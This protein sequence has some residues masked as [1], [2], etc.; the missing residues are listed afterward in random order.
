MIQDPTRPERAPGEH[1]LTRSEE[2]Y[3]LVT[4]ATRDVIWDWDLRT[5]ELVWN[6]AIEHTFG[7]PPDE[8][9]RVISFWYDHVHPEDRDRVVHGIH[10]VIDGGGE[11]WS[12]E[13]RFRRSDGGY[14]EVLDRGLVAHDESGTPVRMIGSMQDIT[15]R[16]RA[17]TALRESERRL[18]REE[19]RSRSLAR[20]L[21]ELAWATDAEGRV[22]DMPEWR[23]FTGQTPEEVRGWGWLDAIHPDEREPTR[24]AWTRFVEQGGHGVYNV[25]YRLRAADG[26]YRWFNA[27]GVPL[28]DADGSIR[29][30]V[31]VLI[32]VDARYR[33]LDE[34]RRSEER[35]RVLSDMIPQHIWITLPDGYH[36]YYNQR[37]Y[38]YTGTTPEQAH[39]AGWADVLHPDDV[40]RTTARWTHSLRTGEPYSIEYRFRRHDGVFR[41]FLGQALPLRDERGEI[42]RWFGTLTDIQ[43]QKEAQAER[44]RLI[45]EMEGKAEE[46]SRLAARLEASNRELDQFAYVASHDLKAPLRGIAN[47]STWIEEDLGASL[48][49][50]VAEH[51]RLLQGRV[52]RME[53]LIDGILRYSRAGRVQEAAETVDTGALVREVTELLG[54]PAG[55]EIRVAPAMPVIE[56][57]R[58]PLQQ[59]FMNLIGN[60]LK[61]GHREG[62]PVRIEV[63][64]RGTD[65]GCEFTVADRGPGIAPEFHEKVFG[66]FQRLQA[67]DEVEGTGIGLSLVR[68]LV[69][70]GGGTIRI[71]SAPGEGARF[72]F[73]WP[74]TA[75]AA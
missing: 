45:G 14:V 19:E 71:E 37:W 72:I 23:G 47:L 65:A 13:Y 54:V 10:E 42:V 59:V 31:G 11:A 57:E 3:R 34:L 50:A 21:A 62:E 6:E 28:R 20:A 30:W 69:E 60:A 36:E 33:A 38:D 17:E 48:S 75:L 66:I 5:D 2:R 18:R 61:Y 74:A 15:E 1:A 24:A 35:F 56:T 40:E 51:I 39:G 55:A 70:S 7:Y 44:E 8:V 26:Q 4:R 29:E 46:L 53:G 22:V 68:K 25:E 52:H 63:S 67:R 49:P 64:A 9:P 32:D 43:D 41:W 12:D 73:T 27:R 16:K 58:L